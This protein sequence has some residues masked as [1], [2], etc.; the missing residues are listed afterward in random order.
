[1]TKCPNCDDVHYT[2]T[3]NYQKEC[4]KCGCVYDLP[5]KEKPKHKD[6]LLG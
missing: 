1:M 5:K 6:V 4:N 2:F 3:K